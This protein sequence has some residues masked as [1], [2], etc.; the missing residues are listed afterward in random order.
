LC[1]VGRGLD[2]VIVNPGCMIG[3]DNPLVAAVTRAGARPRW[4]PSG[5]LNVVDVRHVAD[6][7]IRA[8]DAGRAGH[9]YILGGDNLTGR[10]LVEDLMRVT[11]QPAPRT[12]LPG[13]AARRLADV[14]RMVEMIKPLELPRTAEVLR[15]YPL[16]FWYS[17]QKAIDELGYHPDGAATGIEAMLPPNAVPPGGERGVDGAEVA[18]RRTDHATAP[19]G[20]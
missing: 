3:P 15:M 1:E 7:C 16:F 13:F 6:G 5:G 11:G 19:R 8:I 18:R 20:G 12:V 10:A 17:S 4:L 14:T 9:R 2:A